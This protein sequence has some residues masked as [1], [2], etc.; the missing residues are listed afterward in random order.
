[1]K[2]KLLVLELWGIGD[3]AIATPFLREAATRYAVTLVAKPVAQE[4]QPH[5][6][7][8][9]RVVPWTAP[10]TRFRGKYRLHT[11]PWGELGRLRRTL[12]GEHFA[13]SVSAR[14]DPRDHVVL[15]LAGAR[16]RLGFGRLGSH[17]LLTRS[18]PRPP[19]LAHRYE[20]WRVAGEALGLALPAMEQLA[21]PTPTGRTI[22]VHTGAAQ[23]VRV[24]PLERYREVVHRLRARGH[25]VR[26][27]CDAD[28]QAWWRQNGETEACAPRDVTELLDCLRAAG[29]FVGNDSGPGHLA[30]LLG[31]PTFTVFGPQLP[32]WFRPLHPAAVWVAG[33]PCPYKP[34]HD[35][36]RFPSARCLLD[37]STEAVWERLAV[38][39][40]ERLHGVVGEVRPA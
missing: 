7:P 24:W 11:W 25:A 20:N 35:Y 3:L 12:R 2:P 23:P 8:G 13:L 34:C 32:E 37:H 9:V 18:L 6:W 1:M 38:F 40:N 29:L 10:W 17:V 21:L 33:A 14:W 16:R 15:R 31:V 26:V 27:L 19:P 39:V 36:C 4:L 28:Q 30:A 5:F 22:L